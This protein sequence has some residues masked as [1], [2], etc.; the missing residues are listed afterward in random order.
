VN[1]VEKISCPIYQR[2]PISD[3]PGNQRTRWALKDLSV[4]GDFAEIMLLSIVALSWTDRSLCSNTFGRPFTT[5]YM[6]RAYKKK[7]VGGREDAEDDE[8]SI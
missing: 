4:Q 7:K 1:E 5:R 3:Y 2:R 8:V 6:I